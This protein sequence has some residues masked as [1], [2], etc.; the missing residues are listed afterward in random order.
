MKT[1]TTSKLNQQIKELK[2]KAKLQETVEKKLPFLDPE[3]IGTHHYGYK[4]KRGESGHIWIDL[5]SEGYPF[6]K[7]GAKL[8]ELR[9]LIQKITK[10]F[11]PAKLAT[12]YLASKDVLTASHY[13]LRW[14]NGCKGN[15]KCSINWVSGEYSMTI[16]LPIDFYSDDC[17]GV[18]MRKLYDSEYH[19]FIGM[20]QAELNRMQVRAYKLDMFESIKYYGGD[21]TNYI[22]D[23]DDKEEFEFLLFNGHVKQHAD[24]WQK[25]LIEKDTK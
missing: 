17:K 24:F 20:A 2:A 4:D 23:A 13:V 7:K 8:G 21:V 9:E 16:N 5:H 6:N 10:A 15:F 11:K 18:F 22:E 12:V 25:Q 3:I 19:Y 14:D 1:S